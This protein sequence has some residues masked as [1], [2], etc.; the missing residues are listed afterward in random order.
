VSEAVSEAVLMPLNVEAPTN[1]TPELDETELR[2]MHD[3]LVADE[4]AYTAT[5]QAQSAAS[6]PTD[7]GRVGALQKALI[8]PARKLSRFQAEFRAIKIFTARST[9]M[10]KA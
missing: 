2:T 1:P 9:P 3:D 7:E 4:A 6:I 10:G 8:K 5:L